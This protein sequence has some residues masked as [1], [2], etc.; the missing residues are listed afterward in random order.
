MHILR[1]NLHSEVPSSPFEVPCAYSE[2]SSSHF[3]VHSEVPSAHFEV[4]G[5]QSEVPNLLF[6]VPSPQFEVSN[7]SASVFRFTAI[8]HSRMPARLLHPR[9]PCV[10]GPSGPEAFFSADP[11]HRRARCS[12]LFEEIKTSRDEHDAIFKEPA[13]LLSVE[14]TVDNGALSR[15]REPGSRVRKMSGSYPAR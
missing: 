7:A 10:K 6:E 15:R 8:P 2:V 9:V 4:P 3:E 11:F 5:P 12:P 14:R 13:H 1:A